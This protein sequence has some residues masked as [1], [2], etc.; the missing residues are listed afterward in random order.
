MAVNVARM[1]RRAGRFLTDVCIVVKNTGTTRNDQGDLVPVWVDG[2][3]VACRV[4]ASPRLPREAQVAGQTTAEANQIVYLPAGTDVK[5]QD[6]IRASLSNP[7]FGSQVATLEVT[8]ADVNS[9][10]VVRKVIAS[11]KEI[12]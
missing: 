6:R 12:P 1:Q 10:E 5:A 8:T 11:V 2:V 9:D 3:P 7:A 4:N